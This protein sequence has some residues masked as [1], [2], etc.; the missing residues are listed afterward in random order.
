MIADLRQRAVSGE[1]GSMNGIPFAAGDSRRTTTPQVS[2]RL[3]SWVV[4]HCVRREQ[5]A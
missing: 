3:P 1:K 2:E 4:R 5:G